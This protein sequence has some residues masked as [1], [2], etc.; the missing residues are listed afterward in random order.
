MVAYLSLS[1]PAVIAGLV[2]THL[3]LETTFEVF[4]S[5]VA[6][7]ALS[8]AVEAWRTRPA[9]PA[10]QVTRPPGNPATR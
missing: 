10:H 8:M 1:V 4:G 9:R 7:V 3:G 2:I 6:A 5:I